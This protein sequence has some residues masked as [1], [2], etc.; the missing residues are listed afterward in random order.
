VTRETVDYIKISATARHLME[1]V[2]N[3]AD[4]D[5]V[6]LD[7]STVHVVMQASI[8]LAM[9]AHGIERGAT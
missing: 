1:T 7:A 8:E 9:I 5:G 3:R 2:F 4:A 6:K